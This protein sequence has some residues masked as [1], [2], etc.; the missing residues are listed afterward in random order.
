[1]RRTVLCYSAPE[2]AVVCAGATR[3]RRRDPVQSSPQRVGVGPEGGHVL[4]RYRL[5][6]RQR[7]FLRIF[8]YTVLQVLVMQV[9]TGGETCHADMADHPPL[10]DDRTGAQP[11][12]EPRQMSVD[13]PDAARVD[14]LDD[15]AIAAFDA[16]ESH[17]A[18][19]CRPHRRTDGCRVVDATMG[20]HAVEDGMSTVK[21]EPRTHA[22]ELERC[23]Q[24]RLA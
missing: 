16:D 9:W 8:V 6:L 17:P 1:M 14:D 22:A 23:A 5:R 20:T 21:V 7:H 2:E 18:A 24:E 19:A 11:A 13:R 12:R 10:F 3:G 15:V 4:R